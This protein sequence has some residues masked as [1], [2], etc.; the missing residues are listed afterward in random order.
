MPNN[1]LKKL[2]LSKKQLLAF[3]GMI[4]GMFMSVLD[5]QIVASSL[6]VIASGL[7]ASSNE[8]SW[9][10]TSY[11]IAEVI[12]IPITGFLARLLST[13]ICYF[14]ASLGFTMMS[15]LCSLANNIESM[16][17]FRALQ[18]F[19]G[20]AMIPLV[21][22]TVFIIF[23]ASQRPTVTILIGLIVTVAPTL[24]PT[25]GGYIT[26]ILSWHFMFLLNVIPGIFVCTVVF[27]YVDFDKP[28]YQLLKNF[29]FLGILLMSLTLGLLQYVLE[30]GNKAGWLDNKLILFLSITVALGFILLIIRELTFINPILDLNTF[31]YKDFT[32][33]C[34][35]SFILGI[36]LYGTVYILPLFLF[37]IAKYDTLQIGATMMVTGVAQFLSAPLAGR[38]LGL[39]IDSR[40]MLTIGLGGFALGCHLN[41]FL[42]TDSKFAAFVLPQFIRGF[43]LMF[44]FIPINNIALCNMPKEKIANASGLY[45]LTRNLGG[46]VG[47][48]II[49]TIL[50][51]DTKIFMQY[52]SENISYTSIMALTKLDYYTELLSWKVLNPEQGAYL[53]LADKLNND[54]FVIA[55]NNIFNMIGL[56]FIFIMLLIPFTS[57]IE[58]TGNVNVH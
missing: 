11:L 15:V 27:L 54:A 31:L 2:P 26:E 8:L 3:F 49:S 50:S 34:I 7:A 33:G 37:T 4:V 24:G 29:D 32:F 57:N 56:L 46:A 5:I 36:G 14:I 38:M 23:P 39:G 16:I 48:A 13:R 6:S 17:I 51:N 40:L 41:S 47:L 21:F 1:D 30:E 25:L 58:L 20:G 12:I 45:N 44:C 18:G 42:T 28:N 10:Q 19:C 52:L 9:I 22:S 53:L 35:Y 43:S 55:I